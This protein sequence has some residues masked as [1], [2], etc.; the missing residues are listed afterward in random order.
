M[1]D[2]LLSLLIVLAAL[3]A[4]ALALR[5]AA[6]G[7]LQEGRNPTLSVPAV[8]WICSQPIGET[9]A[10]RSGSGAAPERTVGNHPVTQ[11]FPLP[12]RLLGVGCGKGRK[13]TLRN[14][15]ASLLPTFRAYPTSVSAAVVLGLRAPVLN[16]SLWPSRCARRSTGPDGTVAQPEKRF[17]RSV[18]V[19]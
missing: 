6:R 18:L 9:W 12:L 8:R 19:N 3:V 5:W 13:D 17:P 1:P 16:L 10:R 15:P 4:V 7:S 2:L 11:R 14:Q